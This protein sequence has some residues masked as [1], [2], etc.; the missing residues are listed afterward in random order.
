MRWTLYPEYVCVRVCNVR[1][2]ECKEY[3]EFEHVP[4]NKF[5]R[6]IIF[7]RFFSYSIVA[8]WIHFPFNRTYLLSSCVASN[9]MWSEWESMPEMIT[10][11]RRMF[12]RF[13]HTGISVRPSLRLLLLLWL[14]LLVMMLFTQRFIYCIQYNA[15]GKLIEN[16]NSI[17]FQSRRRL[18]T[19]N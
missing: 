5:A 10:E 18:T 12:H 11:N 6:T 2:S 19:W 3:E 8:C 17:K 15:N 9:T 13:R 4:N 14:L 1:Q 7:I 16:E